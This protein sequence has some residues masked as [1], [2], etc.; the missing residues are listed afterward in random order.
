LFSKI[1]SVTRLCRVFTRKRK[2]ERGGEREGKRGERREREGER[3]GKTVGKTVKHLTSL[4]IN[5]ILFINQKL[6]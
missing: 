4:N 2:K 6:L 5:Y 1:V 3:E